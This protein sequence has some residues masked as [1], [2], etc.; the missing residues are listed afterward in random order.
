[1]HEPLIDVE[2][3][4]KKRRKA[5]LDGVSFTVNRGEILSIIASNGAGKSTL[6]DLLA[7]MLKPDSGDVTYHEDLPDVGGVGY[8]CQ[9]YRSTLFPW[10]TVEKNLLLPTELSGGDVSVA[11]QEIDAFLSKM[12][13]DFPL[14][15][16][17]Y[18]LSGGQQQLVCIIRALAARPSVLLLDEAF[19]ALNFRM[20]F[21]LRDY[22]SEYVR[23]QQITTVI[24]THDVDDA[25]YLSDRVLVAQGVPV[26]GFTEVEVDMPHPR[27]LEDIEG[28]PFVAIKKQVLRSFIK[29]NGNDS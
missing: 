17:P 18:R 9:D 3:L 25:I 15:T 19:S 23:R 2:G 10:F 26:T 8:V 16:Y 4:S 5:V 11:K 7:G 21:L 6:L 24:V 13:A 14:D 20:V 12:G 28:P 29:E 27:T 1:M 22:L